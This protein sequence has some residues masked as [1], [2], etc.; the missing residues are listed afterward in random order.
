MRNK[1]MEARESIVFYSSFFEAI[2][3]LPEEMQAQCYR[4]VIKYG[5]YGEEPEPGNIGYTMFLAFRK[6]IEK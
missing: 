4:A 3:S 2:D 5:L 6:Q 1:D